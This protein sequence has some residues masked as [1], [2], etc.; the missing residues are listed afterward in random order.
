MNAAEGVA[1]ASNPLYMIRK[2]IWAVIAGL[3]LITVLSVG[4]DSLVRT[5]FPAA[6]GPAGQVQSRVAGMA[7]I[8]YAAAF[9]AFGSYLTAR[10]AGARPIMHAM[11]VG[12]IVLL[13]VLI[14]LARSWQLAPLWFNLGFVAMILPS[15]WLGGLMRARQVRA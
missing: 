7:T 10:L 9:G 6:F 2:S 3:L 4:A 15:A 13:I 1:R 5:L 14:E 11:I 8:L 12:G